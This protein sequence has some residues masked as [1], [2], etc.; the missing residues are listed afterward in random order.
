MCTQWLPSLF[1]LLSTVLCVVAK[2]CVAYL[3]FILFGTYSSWT[4]LRFYQ[5]KSDGSLKGDPSDEF[6]FTTFFPELL[7]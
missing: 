5:L 6:A 4:Y 3:P 2:Q 7:Q 1:I